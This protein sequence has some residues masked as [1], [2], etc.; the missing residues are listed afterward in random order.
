MT[1]EIRKLLVLST[2]HLP[3]PHLD[4]DLGGPV[5]TSLWGAAVIT[6]TEHGAFLWVPDEPLESSGDGLTPQLVLDIQVFAR[7]NGCDYVMFDADGPK[8]AA[9][10]LFDW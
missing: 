2:A 10:Q 3:Q 4:A 1:P 7:A 6:L 8:V 9:L 5:D